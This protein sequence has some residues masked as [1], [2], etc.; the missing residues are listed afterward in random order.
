MLF[1]NQLHNTWFWPQAAFLATKH[2]LTVFVHQPLLRCLL[3]WCRLLG[4]SKQ[5]LPEHPREAENAPHPLFHHTAAALSFQPPMG[6][7]VQ[8]G[9]DQLIRTS[10]QCRANIKVRPGC[11]M[12]FPVR[13][14]PLR[15]EI[16]PCL[17]ALALVLNHSP[18]EPF[19]SSSRFFSQN[20]PCCSLWSSPLVFCCAPL[21]RVWLHLPCNSPLG[22]RRQQLVLPTL[23][24]PSSLVLNK[25]SMYIR[26]LR[27]KLRLL[28]ETWVSP[29]LLKQVHAKLVA[30]KGPCARLR[31]GKS[32]HIYLPWLLVNCISTFGVGKK[33]FLSHVKRCSIHRA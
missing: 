31:L 20:F 29:V 30:R 24:A 18:F 33:P 25:P 6:W 17:W 26:L 22:T 12:L 8:A 1:P 27:E 16:S 5:T 15:M 4:Q 14:H 11:S 28:T 23:L 9:R 13:L 32:T 10:A 3:S 21:L 2:Q 19:F 7:I